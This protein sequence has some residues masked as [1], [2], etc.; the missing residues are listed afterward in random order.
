[1]LLRN[2][3]LLLALSLGGC[4][5]LADV[6]AGEVGCAPSEIVISNENTTFG[7]RTWSAECN[8]QLYHCSS[9]GGGEGSTAQISCAPAGGGGTPAAATTPP[10]GANAPAGCQY[11][12]QCKG[13]RICKDGECVDTAPAA[14][15]GT[16]GSSEPAPAPETS[17]APPK[18]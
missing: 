11:D 2:L 16:T 10:G 6:S 9:H 1:M 15:P 13:D 4:T 5:T 14:A 7:G 8:G 3:P 17:A 12:T 18:S